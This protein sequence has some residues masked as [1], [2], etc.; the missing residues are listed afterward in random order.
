MQERRQAPRHKYYLDLAKRAPKV[1]PNDERVRYY[2]Q[3]KELGQDPKSGFYQFGNN[4]FMLFL[5]RQRQEHNSNYF[6][7]RPSYYIGP[8]EALGENWHSFVSENRELINNINKA[9]D[10]D[11]QWRRPLVLYFMDLARR[12]EWEKVEELEKATDHPLGITAVQMCVWDQL[13]PLL[14]QA[15]ETMSQCGIDAKQ[16]YS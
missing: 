11:E 4:F 12:G 13:N 1:D 15:S 14:K 10:A 7:K 6:T 9:L 2:V 3:A 16:F 8:A 5:E